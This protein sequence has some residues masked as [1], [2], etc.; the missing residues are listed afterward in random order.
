MKSEVPDSNK[1]PLLLTSKQAAAFLS[2]SPRKLWSL[3]ASGEIPCVRM[4]RCVR[5]RREALL[6][7]VRANEKGGGQATT[8]SSSAP[9]PRDEGVKS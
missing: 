4:G 9:N 1:P 7:F 3:T 2:I 6:E 5:Y 8:P